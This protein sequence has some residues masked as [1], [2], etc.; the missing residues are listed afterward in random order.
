MEAT[1]GRRSRNRP[2]KESGD[3]ECSS[4]GNSVKTGSRSTWFNQGRGQSEAMSR[5]KSDDLGGF[6]VLPRP[7]SPT[8][9]TAQGTPVGSRNSHAGQSGHGRH[10]VRQNASAALR[11]KKNVVEPKWVVWSR[12]V[13]ENNF[14]VAWTAY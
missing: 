6:Q 14:F 11:W 9:T 7:D 2:S 12:M 10:A 4:S 13:V 3:Y 1:P 5:A 8:V